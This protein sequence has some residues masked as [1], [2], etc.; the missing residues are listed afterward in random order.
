METEYISIR[1]RVVLFYYLWEFYSDIKRLSHYLYM[2]IFLLLLIKQ[3]VRG[4]ERMHTKTNKT[5]YFSRLAQI[6]I[7]FV[8]E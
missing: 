5:K 8:I 6:K 4:Y 7:Y 3:A 1:V 2:K